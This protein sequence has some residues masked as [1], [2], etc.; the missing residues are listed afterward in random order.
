MCVRCVFRAQAAL[1]AALGDGPSVDKANSESPTNWVR[2]PLVLT[3]RPSLP[4]YLSVYFCLLIYLYISLSLCSSTPL[5]PYRLSTCLSLCLSV[6]L[7]LC[8][9]LFLCVYVSGWMTCCLSTHCLSACLFSVYV[10]LCLPLHL[11]VAGCLSTH[12][13]F[14]SLSVLSVCLSVYLSVVSVSVSLGGWRLARCL[15]IYLFLLCLCLCLWVA[16]WPAVYSPSCGKRSPSVAIED[17]CTLLLW[18][19][20]LCMRGVSVCAR[21]CVCCVCDRQKKEK[22]TNNRHTR[23]TP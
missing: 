5:R 19:P 1:Q 9:S 12:C 23:S 21:V 10:C 8:L 16:A 3:V 4:I 18:A 13:V 7:P 6:S 14:S 11:W 17:R 22:H 2:A 20:N 15:S